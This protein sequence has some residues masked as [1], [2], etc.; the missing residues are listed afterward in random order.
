MDSSD[1]GTL[2]DFDPITYTVLSNRRQAYDQMMWQAPA[3]SLTAQA[4]LFS[5]ALAAGS[6]QASRLVA[7]S[8][9]LLISF[10]SVQLMGKHRHHERTS[11]DLLETL[12]QELKIRPVHQVRHRPSESSGPKV[13]TAL[14]LWHRVID[15]SSYK[16]WVGGLTLFGV[17]AAVVLVISAFDPGLFR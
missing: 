10:M 8:L 9:A 1:P 2:T 4:F 15:L 5:I 12:E 13:T 11:A 16:V 17:A 3:L 14:P 7:S 6:A